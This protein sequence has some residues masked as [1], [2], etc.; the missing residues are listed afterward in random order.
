MINDQD[1]TE[2]LIRYI[3]TITF[4]L[5]FFFSTTN[6]DA[7]LMECIEHEPWIAFNGLHIWLGLGYELL[8]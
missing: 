3:T 5:F 7:F 4:S 6:E 8:F 1:I 2:S